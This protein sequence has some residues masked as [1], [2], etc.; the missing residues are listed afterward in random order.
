MMASLTCLVTHGRWCSPAERHESAGT[1][2]PVTAETLMDC[3]A[4]RFALPRRSGVY[5]RHDRPHVGV[6]RPQQLC[7]D[8]EPSSVTKQVNKVIA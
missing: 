7:L 6:G 3:D 5:S 8:P 4:Q 2:R 1:I